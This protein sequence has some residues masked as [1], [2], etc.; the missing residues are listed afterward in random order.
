SV[1]MTTRVAALSRARSHTR[2]IMGSPQISSSGSFGRRVEPGRAGM[3]TTKDMAPTDQDW[4]A[5]S[6]AAIRV[7]ATHVAGAL[8][9]HRAESGGVCRAARLYL[10]WHTEAGVRTLAVSRLRGITGPA[11]PARF[12]CETV[13]SS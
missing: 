13:V 2:G 8:G 12:R 4:D 5:R 11:N 1:A 3:I 6:L 10:A 7:V 9:L